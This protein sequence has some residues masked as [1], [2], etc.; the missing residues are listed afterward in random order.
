MSTAKRAL[1]FL[2]VALF[3][4]PAFSAVIVHDNLG[5]KGAGTTIAVLDSGI[6]AVHP[7]LALGDTAA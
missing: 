6:Y 1:F 5:Y 2:I 7:D 4:L 3:S